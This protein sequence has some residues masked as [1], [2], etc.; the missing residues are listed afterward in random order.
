MTCPRNLLQLLSHISC[1]LMFAGN[2]YIGVEVTPVSQLYIKNGRTL[3]F[4]I[5]F[6]PIVEVSLEGYRMS[7]ISSGSSY[8]CEC[9]IHWLDGV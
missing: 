4:P 7:G 6:Y 2:G 1:V 3:T 5:R 9:Y 8:T